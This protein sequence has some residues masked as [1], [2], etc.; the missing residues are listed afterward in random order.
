MGIVQLNLKHSENGL[1]QI[2]SML[3][4]AFI[5]IAKGCLHKRLVIINDTYKAQSCCYSLPVRCYIWSWHYLCSSS[6]FHREGWSGLT[7]SRNWWGSLEQASCIQ[8]PRLLAQASR[9]FPGSHL[10][11][12]VLRAQLKHSVRPAVRGRVRLL[13]AH[14]APPRTTS[15]LTDGPN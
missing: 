8:A 15:P 3:Q 7:F 14:P 2:Y 1:L 12:W 6:R 13:A 4:Y 5:T 9:G 10:T 11:V